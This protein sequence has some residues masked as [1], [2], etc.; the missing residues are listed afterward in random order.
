MMKIYKTVLIFLA[1]ALLF[2]ACED[3][4]GPELNPD[5]E[6]PAFQS[7]SSGDRIPLLEEEAGEEVLVFNW[8]AP[9]FGFPAAVDYRVE[10]GSPDGDFENPVKIGRASCMEG[11]TIYGI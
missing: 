10:M 9:D 6:P 1:G 3:S 11:V 2:A 8:T 5:A 4:L 7:P